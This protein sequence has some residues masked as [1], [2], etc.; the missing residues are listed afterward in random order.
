MKRL[1]L[2]SYTIPL[3]GLPVLGIIP[4][5]DLQQLNGN[6][7]GGL[8]RRLG[9]PREIPQLE[10]LVTRTN[11][12]SPASEAY[13]MLRTSVTFA[14]LGQKAQVIVVTSA[15]PGD[16]K[17]TSSA[18][19]AMTLAQQGVRTLLVD[20]DLRK[21][22]LHEIL[23]VPREP[24]L[25][26][27][28]IGSIPVDKAIVEVP[29]GEGAEVLHFLPGGA[30]PPNP[31]ELLGS[32]LMRDL[33]VQL[34]SSYDMVIIDAPPLNL[35]TDASVLG[36]AAD[37]TILIARAGVTEKRALGHAASQL[38]HLHARI[39]GIVLNDLDVKRSGYGGDYYAY[40][41]SNGKNGKGTGT[42][43]G[44]E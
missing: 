25:A 18:N 35:V 44:I 1:L 43:T 36:T 40:G 22:V 8:R 3:G 17:S 30:Y 20:A 11:P 38:G 34:R 4:R 15:M 5:L 42:G 23:G 28:L 21:G 12:L 7:G 24:G 37:A 10:R 39:S 33:I 32:D 31:A 13:R 6:G 14:N 26:H 19:L 9:R 41:Y 27:L 2:T 16:G 29:T